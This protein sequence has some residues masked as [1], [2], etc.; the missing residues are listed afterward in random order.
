MLVVIGI[1]AILLA[2]T[3]P[4]INSLAK[5]GGQKAAVSNLMNALEGLRPFARRYHWPRDL[6]RFCR[7][8]HTGSISLQGL[9]C[10]SGRCELHSAGRHE[11]EFPSDGHLLCPGSGVSSRNQAHQKSSSPARA[12]SVP[13]PSSYHSSSSIAVEWFLCRPL[14]CG[15]IC[16]QAWSITAGNK[17]SPIRSTSKWKYDSVVVVRF[18][19]RARYVDPYS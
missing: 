6:C 17:A 7:P 4:A 10:L 15:S 12:T 9:H 18:S 3:L 16:L 5:A 11:M 8:E 1:I 19:G 2:A 13:A 14:A